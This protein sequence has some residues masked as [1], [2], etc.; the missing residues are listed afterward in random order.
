MACEPSVISPQS[1]GLQ[2]D[3][4][5]TPIAAIQGDG[6]VSALAGSVATIYGVVTRLDPGA[7]F[8]LEEPGSDGSSGTSNGIFVEDES[9][10][11]EVG[12][13]QQLMMTGRVAELGQSRDTLT[14]LTGIS[15]IQSC[16]TGLDL[17][18]TPLA[19]P[20]DSRQREAVESMRVSFEQLLTVTDVYNF[21]RGEVTLSANGILRAPTEDNHPGK[22]FNSLVKEN[23]ERSI[24]A[25]L[26]SG[27]FPLLPGGSTIEAATG[28]VGYNGERQMLIIEQALFGDLHHPPPLAEPAVDVIR[29]ANMNLLNFFNGDGTGQD[30]SARHGAKSYDEFLEQA[31]RIKSA[32]AVIQPSLVA[33]QELENDG[34]GPYSAARSLLDL[35]NEAVPGEWSVV[36]TQSGKVGTGAI[37]VG[38]FFRAEKLEAVGAPHLN[39]AAP[40]RKLSREPMAQLF[41]D[42]A[43]SMRFLLAVNHLKSKGSCPDNGTNADQHDG[44]SCWNAARVDAARAVTGWVNKL[45]GGL[46]ADHALVLGDMNAYRKEDPIRQFR[47][48]AYTELVEHVSGLPQHSYVYWGQAGTLDYAFATGS[49]VKFVRHAQIWHIN[50]DWPQKMELPKPWL[51]YSDH[52]PIVI[53]LDFSQAATSN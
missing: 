10:S 51:R 31:H 2:C 48:A 19:L 28:I 22:A 14:A 9:L 34:F 13:G 33:V 4:D 46:G 32:L 20:L 8:Y 7:G 23:R 6:Y 39:D 52:D 30:F 49:L 12:V 38:L 3:A 44:Q 18:L 24:V 27:R 5:T 37:S 21:Y 25:G 40:F 45:L 50:V 17:P 36:E 16:T 1:A 53:D 11:R 15:A 26:D 29:I 43:S 35:L 42:R 41:R 47:Q